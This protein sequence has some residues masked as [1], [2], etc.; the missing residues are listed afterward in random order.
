MDPVD[1]EAPVLAATFALTR[2][3]FI[4]AQ[5]FHARHKIRWV[6]GICGGIGLLA[7]INV[8][9]KPD[10]PS[11][12]IDGI[13]QIFGLALACPLL[14]VVMAILQFRNRRGVASPTTFSWFQDRIECTTAMSSSKMQWD[15]FI[16]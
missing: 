11:R 15:L 4:R 2:A 13:V 6:S 7:L 8:L 12:P 10:S 5:L 9:Q 16:C 1:V 3:E 14:I